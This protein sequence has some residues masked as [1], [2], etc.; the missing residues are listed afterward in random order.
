MFLFF[1]YCVSSDILAYCGENVT[2][3][4][5]VGHPNTIYYRGSGPIT[6]YYLFDSPYTDLE[7]ENGITEIGDYVFKGHGSITS[8]SLPDSLSTIGKYAFEGCTNLQS[9]DCYVTDNVMLY[10]EGCFANC[11]SLSSISIRG[12]ITSIPPFMFYS[13][14]TLSSF[15]IPDS[16]ISIGDSA[17][18]FCTSL[19]SGGVTNQIGPSLRTIGNYCFRGCSVLSSFTF[20]VLI[21]DIGVGAFYE[22]T[23]L[24]SISLFNCIHIISDYAF[25][26]CSAIGSV[27]CSSSIS[28]IGNCAFESCS[29]LTSVSFG[30]IHKIGYHAFFCESLTTFNYQSLIPP[31]EVDNEAFYYG[32]LTVTTSS[33][34]PSSKFGILP[35]SQHIAEPNYTS[36]VYNIS[37]GVLII[38]ILLLIALICIIVFFFIFRKKNDIVADRTIDG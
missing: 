18:S 3:E 26:K 36:L 24:S 6:C 7:I 14:T 32:S 8:V 35:T 4:N 16:V 22:C 19:T 15:S 23:A 30:T 37:I 25:Y 38:L 28:M 29:A 33:D 5:D 10:K 9:V 34:Y 17:F 12:S 13:C 11:G 31:S 2:I 1:V 21:S 27:S 20:S